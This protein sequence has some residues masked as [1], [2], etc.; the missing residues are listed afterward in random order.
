MKDGTIEILN[1]ETIVRIGN[2]GMRIDAFLLR[3][4]RSPKILDGGRSADMLSR[5]LNKVDGLS[6]MLKGMK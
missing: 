4:I 3:S 5:I 6:K 2:M 1:R